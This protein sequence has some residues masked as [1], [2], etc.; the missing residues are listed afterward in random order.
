MRLLS[1]AL[2]FCLAGAVLASDPKQAE[3]SFKDGL[4]W[5]KGIADFAQAI[6]DKRAPRCSPHQ[7]RHVLELA[8]KFTE[9]TRTGLPAKL[10]TRFD[11]PAPV[12]D[13]A[14]WERP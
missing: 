3:K 6:R 8:E 10:V 13:L 5:G 9:S 4:D 7:A 12:T 1:F 2:L 14:P 11:P